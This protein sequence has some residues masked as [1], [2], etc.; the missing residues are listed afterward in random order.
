MKISVNQV[1]SLSY[2]LHTTDQNNQKVH[3]ET[4]GEDHPLVFLYGIGQML[5][6][7]EQ[8]IEGLTIGDAFDFT[9]PSAEGYGDIDETAIVEVPT[10]IFLLEGQ[11][12]STRFFPGAVVPLQDQEGNV[13]QAQILKINEEQATLDFNHPMAGKDLYFT[14]KILAVRAATPEELDHGHVHGPG[15]V[16]HD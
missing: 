16:H 3:V 13:M 4:A 5:P 9:I 10:S 14:G 6:L 1:V 12:D 15:G 8:N 11:L 7:F 2:T